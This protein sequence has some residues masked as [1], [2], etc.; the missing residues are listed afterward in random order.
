MSLSYPE[1][2][3]HG[4]T[5]EISAGY[6]AADHKPDLEIGSAVAVHYLA[7][8]ASTDGRF[9]LYRWD[10]GPHSGGAAPH[11]HRTMSESFFVVSVGWSSTSFPER[12]LP[13]QA[14]CAPG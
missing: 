12:S 2:L 1:A 6:R 10:A 4:A 13:E 9:G 8:G 3:Y 14:V 11:F 7:T 5:G